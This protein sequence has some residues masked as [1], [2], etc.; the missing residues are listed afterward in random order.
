M[1]SPIHKIKTPLDWFLNELCNK[2]FL[3]KLPMDEFIKA[4]QMEKIFF[5]YR[6]ADN[7]VKN[8]NKGGF[9]SDNK[10]K[11]PIKHKK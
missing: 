5:N 3:S 11:Q 1:K 4:K 6:E 7:N 8:W 10:Y 2:D 9:I